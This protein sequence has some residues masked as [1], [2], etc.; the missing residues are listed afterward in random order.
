MKLIFLEW[1]LIVRNQRLKQQ[2]PLIILAFPL[3]IYMQLLNP[4][5]FVIE[6]FLIKE[7]Y[8]CALFAVTAGFAPMAFGV[9]AGF[10]E[11]QL[12]MPLSVFEI[13]QA[14]YRFSVILAILLF[15]VFLPTTFLEIKFTE[16][17]A[18]LLFA[19]GFLFFVLF[20]SAPFSYKPYDIKAS[21]FYNYQGVDLGN[22]LYPL[23]F[24][25]ISIGIMILSYLFF[26][27]NITLIVMSAIGF[28]FVATH[29][30]WL[31]AI[32]RKF[33]KTK[34]YRLERFRGK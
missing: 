18:A 14:K 25:A 1:K 24:L 15:I 19:I 21:N 4:G 5:S 29:K 26:N 6:N 27:E 30:I 8:L 16:L 34:Y 3:L 12:T 17:V 28:V 31:K 23:L 20:Y 9:N 33:E 13:L 10:I 22:Y 11:K 7:L 2:F 32:S